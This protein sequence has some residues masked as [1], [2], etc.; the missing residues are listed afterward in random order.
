MGKY[1]NGSFGWLLSQSG[2][3]KGKFIASVILALFS[4]LCGIVPYYFVAAIVR[5]LLEGSTD[6]SAYIVNC[7]IIL[8]L[9]LGHSLF[10]ALSTAN[11]HLATFHTLA[12][13]RKK[14][15][16]KLA[17]M[18][19]G[20]V[21]AQ[22]SGSLKSTIVERI[23][24]IETTLA[25]IL[26]EFTTGIGA[27]II[28]LV[29]V[30]AISW[31]LG[32]AALITIP[33]GIICYCLMMFGYEENYSRAVRA[34][35]ALNA[36]TAEYINGIEVIKVFGKSESSYE[37]FSDA[38]RESAA[39]FVDWMRKCNVYMTFAMCIMPATMLSVLPIGGIMAMHG[40]ITTADFI[41]VI[42]LTVGLI[43]PLLGVMSY[44][45]DIAQMDTIVTEVR[46][47]IDAPEM[48][49][50]EKLTKT[51]SG[52]DI[53]L[54]N[55]RFSYSDKE[56]LHGISMTIPEGGFAALVG[57]S[58]SGKSTAA[59]LI[60]SLWDTDSGSISL[61]GVDIKDIPLD[62]LNDRIAYVSQD[63]FLFDL[64]VRENI[65]IGRQDA[66]DKEVE[67]AAKKCG[68]H[69]FI[70][71]LENGY[72][73]VVGTSGGHLSGGE[74]QRIAIARAMLKNA[75]IIILDEA[76]AY[77]DPEN[78]AII[79]RSVSR[80]V[81]GKTLIVIAHR[82]STVKNADCIYVINDGVI[83]EQG[84][85]EQLLGSNGLY[86]SMWK[87]HISAKDGEDNV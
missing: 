58:G 73:T 38:A 51:F 75:G 71:G 63:N 17:K 65:R 43:E 16:D 79:Q 24:S 25:H 21:L 40:T 34:T 67:E 11:S 37:K 6:K 44:S 62:E 32:L 77:T 7:L 52:G 31:K 81:S 66:T 45:D 54:D 9:W 64:S 70:M 14:A 22:P 53:V 4:M 42:I 74:R 61:G 27:P 57:P 23:D 55:V 46:S 2:E 8:A 48:K 84:T 29:C 87:A 15:L 78:E 69:D 68:C 72:D 5:D 56:V 80:L 10:H 36:V 60:A 28:V 13:I 26:P 35:K 41:T 83:A 82:L 30:F 76:T 47:I 33:L 39:S 85:H 3:R 19:L 18:P 50:P 86:S 12:V 49:R 1:K 20:D 59:R